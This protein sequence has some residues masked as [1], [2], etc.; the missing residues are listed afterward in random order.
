M[1]RTRLGVSWDSEGTAQLPAQEGAS[2]EAVEGT[3]LWLS[4]SAGGEKNHSLRTPETQRKCKLSRHLPG[5][6]LEFPSR[7]S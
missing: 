3:H 1:D 6:A 4:P 5:W 7:E 2:S